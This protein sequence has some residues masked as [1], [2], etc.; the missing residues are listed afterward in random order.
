MEESVSTKTFTITYGIKTPNKYHGH[1][2]RCVGY[3]LIAATSMQ[4]ARTIA[5]QNMPAK[6]NSFTVRKGDKRY[7]MPDKQ[8]II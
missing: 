2:Y 1:D 8:F 5:A 4:Q 7:K 3:G 6:A